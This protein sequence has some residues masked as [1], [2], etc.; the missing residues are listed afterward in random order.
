MQFVNYHVIYHARS[1]F[2]DD[3]AAGLVRRLLRVWLCMPNH[4]ALP[5]D[6]AALWVNTEPGHRRGGIGQAPVA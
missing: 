6:Q 2:A 3:K 5:E 1:A 4:R